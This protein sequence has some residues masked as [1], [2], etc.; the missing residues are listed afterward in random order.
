MANFNTIYGYTGASSGRNKVIPLTLASTTETAFSLGT[1]AGTTSPAILTVPGVGY[2]GSGS[3]LEFNLNSAISLASYGRKGSVQ[4]EMPYFSAATFDAGRPFV[5][6]A[7]GTYSL[8]AGSGNT[9][10]VNL[11]LGTSATLG[12]DTKIGALT[13]AGSP[14]TTGQ[15]YLSTTIQWDITTGAV[16]GFYSGNVGNTIT[17][18]HALSNAATAAASTNLQFV[19]SGVFGNAGGGTISVAEWS[20]EQL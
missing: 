10:A 5:V 16:S 18:G 20:I 11:Y 19:L 7:F 8:N 15:W 12:S 3:P 17:A 6:R 1:D 9:A 14:S 4:T 13:A 2:V